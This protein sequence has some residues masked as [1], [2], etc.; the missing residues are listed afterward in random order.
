MLYR[1]KNAEPRRTYNPVHA[2]VQKT[3]SQN[4]RKRLLHSRWRGS[5]GFTALAA[6]KPR[7]LE[8]TLASIQTLVRSDLPFLPPFPS[9]SSPPPPPALPIAYFLAFPLPF[10]FLA[11]PGLPAAL[12][13][14]PPPS[15][16]SRNACSNSLSRFTTPS[17]AGRRSALKATHSTYMD[18][19]SAGTSAGRGDPPRA[20]GGLPARGG[21]GQGGGGGE[22]MRRDGQVR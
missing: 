15:L 20:L 10:P 21:R 4:G 3:I 13:A 12:A 5:H 9:S 11:S 2:G 17:N 6:V 8:S 18:R 7:S 22:Q 1:Y 19:R 16:P 14:L